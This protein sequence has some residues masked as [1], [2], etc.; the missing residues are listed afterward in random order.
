MDRL[1]NSC[2]HIKDGE[3]KSQVMNQKLSFGVEAESGM[4]GVINLV[5]N[6]HIFLLLILGLITQKDTTANAVITD[7]WDSC[8]SISIVTSIWCLEMENEN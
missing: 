8:I 7:L 1:N 5:W 6:V 2:N 3:F 4:S